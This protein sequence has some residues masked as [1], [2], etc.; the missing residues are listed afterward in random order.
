VKDGDGYPLQGVTV[1]ITGDN[2]TDSTDTDGNGQYEFKGLAALDYTLRYKKD[3]Y[4]TQTKSVSLEEDE[5]KDLGTVTMEEQTVLGKI[6]GYVV[7]IKGNPIESVKLKLKGLKTKLK[8]SETSDGDGFFEFTD[9]EADKYVISAQKKRYRNAKQTVS[10]EEGE[11]LE[12]EIEM[13]K[14]SKRIKGLLLEEDIQ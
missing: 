1:T 9:L 10:L 3:G 13:R 2:F 12:I 4:Q 11:E 5:V 14:S 7:D 8:M 6:Y